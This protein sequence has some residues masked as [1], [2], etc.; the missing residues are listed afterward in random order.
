M[1]KKYL[2]RELMSVSTFLPIRLA[3]L[4]GFLFLL[5]EKHFLSA[6][7]LLFVI[8]TNESGNL[9]S[10]LGARRLAVNSRL[11]PARLFPE[12]E[13]TVWLTLEN[14]KALPV[15]IDW[16]QP[17]PAISEP[18]HSPGYV[19]GGTASGRWSVGWYAKKD[20]SFQVKALKRGYYTL[21]ALRLLSRDL[22]GLFYKELRQDHQFRLFVYPRLL[23]LPNLMLTPADLIGPQQDRRPFLPDPIMFA[24]LR[25]YTASMPART[26][27]WKASARQDQLLSRIIEPSADFRICMAI[28]AANF[29]HPEPLEEQFEEALS[30]AATLAMWADMRRI[31]FGLLVNARQKE[32]P[33]PAAVS[34]SSGV[35]QIRL[36]LESL[37]RV[38]LT[39]LGTLERLLRIESSRLPWGTT[40]VVIGGE[41]T[42]TIPSI[43][44]KVIY[45]STLGEAHDK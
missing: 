18:M 22:F 11:S 1:L 17:S 23:S 33:G 7:F 30:L 34:V 5:K 4:A 8:L 31:P 13:T 21:P 3:L 2:N 26:I 41:D 37:A 45:L 14:N 10:V 29:L 43:I 39:Q 16:I 35:D 12:E 24:G 20:A 42:G 32:L 25:E 36:V 38:E 6:A 9:W 44:R 27:H 15:F 40:L 28:D 19:L